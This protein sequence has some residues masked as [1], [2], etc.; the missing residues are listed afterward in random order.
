MQIYIVNIH[1]FP[2]DLDNFIRA[3]IDNVSNSI[4][5]PGIIGFDFIQ[6]IDDPTKFMLFEVYKNDEARNSHKE[7][8]HYLRWRESVKDMMVEPRSGLSYKKIYP[9]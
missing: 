5:E 9:L 1:V 7:T 2:N 8:D 6:Q 4:K 3:T